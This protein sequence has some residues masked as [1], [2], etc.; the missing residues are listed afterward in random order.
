M[1]P[2]FYPPRELW[3][4]LNLHKDPKSREI[5]CTWGALSSSRDNGC[6]TCGI[7]IE[8][9]ESVGSGTTEFDTGSVFCVEILESFTVKVTCERAPEGEHLIELDKFAVEFHG[10]ADQAIPWKAFGTAAILT[11][12]VGIADCVAF[13]QKRMKKCLQHSKCL[14]QERSTAPTRLIDVGT[15]KDDVRL[16]ASP[17]VGK[18]YTTL[19]YAWGD[20]SL[21]ITTTANFH[22]RCKNVPWSTLPKT[23]QDAISITRGLGIQYLWIDSICIIQ[24]SKSDWEF[25]GMNMANIYTGSYLTLAAT[26]ASD[27]SEGL[28]SSRCNL[29]EESDLED[30][31][32]HEI[33][34]RSEDG[35]SNYSIFARRPVKYSHVAL[36]TLDYGVGHIKKSPLLCRAWVLQER[37]LSIRTIHFCFEEMVWECKTGIDCECGYGT[38]ISGRAKSD[39]L[40]GRNVFKE[41]FT[42]TPPSDVRTPDQ[43][44]YSDQEEEFL[45]AWYRLIIYY[46]TLSITFPSDRLPALRGM[47]KYLEQKMGWTYLEGLWVHDF[48]RGA[49]YH[50][51]GTR[52]CRRRDDAPTWSWAS[53]E[54]CDGWV[55]TDYFRFPME[56]SKD[57]WK[58]DERFHVVA[59]SARQGPTREDAYP[60]EELRLAK[61]PFIA[62][63]AAFMDATIICQVV[64]S[65]EPS[66][67]EEGT[68]KSDTTDTAMCLSVNDNPNPVSV[69]WDI[70]DGNSYAEISEGDEVHAIL[71][72][73][74]VVD[75]V[76]FGH[77]LVLKK[78]ENGLH[79]RVGHFSAPDLQGHFRGKL[80]T[81]VVLV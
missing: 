18:A 26:S 52:I 10:C 61:K 1:D 34:R 77:G 62:I 14:S 42:N 76:M 21:P 59:H 49:L 25:E 32:E 17:R 15:G 58:V 41:L 71:L 80:I 50:R 3:L 63:E 69:T 44:S 12:D 5:H 73:H 81:Q 66:D 37:L 39:S 33:K 8:G 48:V 51:A 35:A 60:S 40:L 20:M 75:N 6:E 72:A 36:L 54:L 70:V 2:K 47:T 13:V 24:D 43:M 45:L 64:R 31:Q 4:G 16:E 28:L 55:P 78:D 38:S 67:S 56:K 65:P 9:I 74:Y 29:N 53:T 23:F 11:R 79:K 27:S 7:L 22:Q 30:T 19:S 57:S 46:T 68:A